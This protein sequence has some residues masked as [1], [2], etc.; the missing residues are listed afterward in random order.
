MKSKFKSILLTGAAAAMIFTAIPAFASTSWQPFAGTLPVMQNWVKLSTD[1]NN[2]S[3]NA[4]ASISSVGGSYKMNM[5]VYYGSTQVSNQY[6]G[7]TDGT[8]A[9]F[10]LDRSSQGHTV[11]LRGW[12]ANFSL[13]TVAYSGR[14]RGDTN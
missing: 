2:N 10:I 12:T 4:E 14:F 6:D 7:A 8:L 1:S 3:S 9:Q 11:E 5:D 13:Q